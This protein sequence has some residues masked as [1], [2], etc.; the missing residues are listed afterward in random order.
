MEHLETHHRVVLPSTTWVPIGNS[1]GGTDSVRPPENLPRGQYRVFYQVT[2]GNKI[3]ST[4][5]HFS[6]DW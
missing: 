6:V 1:A 5:H 4:G 3:I 2:D